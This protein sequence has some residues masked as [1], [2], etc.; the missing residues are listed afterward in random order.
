MLSKIWAILVILKTAQSN[1]APKRRK[2]AQSGHPA[3]SGL[4]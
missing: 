1:E 4:K 3:S 2:L